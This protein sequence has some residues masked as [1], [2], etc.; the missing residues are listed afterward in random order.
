MLDCLDLNN[1]KNFMSMI[2]TLVKYLETVLN[3]VLINFTYLRG[4]CRENKLCMLNCSVREL[5]VRE[6]HGGWF[7]GSFWCF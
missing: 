7:N 5:L 2:V 4:I 1:E 6:G 3:M